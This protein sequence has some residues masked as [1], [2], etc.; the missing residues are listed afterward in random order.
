VLAAFGP[1]AVAEPQEVFFPD[2]IQH[3]DQR[4]LD[5]LVLQRGYA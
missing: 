3:F 1:E 2:R 4:A 5:D